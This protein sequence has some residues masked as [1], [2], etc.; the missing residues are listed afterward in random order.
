MRKL[1]V[2][3]RPQGTCR[4][5]TSVADAALGV[6]HGQREILF[7]RR[8]LQAVIHDDDG[9]ALR[10]GQGGARHAVARHDR[11]RHP[12]QQQCLVTDLGR[13]IIVRIDQF[14]SGD[15]APIAAAETEWLLTRLSQRL[16]QSYHCR[17]LAGPAQCEI[18]DTEHRQFRARA[19]TRHASRGDRAIAG[20]HGGEQGDPEP[21]FLPPE[22]R[23]THGRFVAPVEVATDRVRARTA[24][25]RARR[26]GSRPYYRHSRPRVRARPDA[27]A[28]CRAGR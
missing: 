23:L 20:S 11:G 3:R 1:Q 19:L 28:T 9:C 24:C 4:K 14:R 25:A 27:P 10:P 16:R 7:Q 8:V 12:R 2:E 22:A 26:R 18:A 6:D 17:R 15:A 5:H 21:G 13:M